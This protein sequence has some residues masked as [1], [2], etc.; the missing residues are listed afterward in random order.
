MLPNRSFLP[1]ALLLASS[2]VPATVVASAAP[3]AGD[4]LVGQTYGA[5]LSTGTPVAIE[6]LLGTGAA[7]QD[8]PVVVAGRVSAVCQQKGC[9]LTLVG[10]DTGEVSVRMTFKGYGFFVPKNLAGHAVVAEGIFQ[11]KTVSVADQRHLAKDAGKSAE[12]IDRITEE[13]Q[14]TSFEASGV[15]VVE[16]P[17]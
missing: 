4:E 12:E 8:Q 9:W 1:L 10:G 17:R 5:A 2:F 3:A 6:K 7:S 15:R 14:E 16:G 11:T 13:K